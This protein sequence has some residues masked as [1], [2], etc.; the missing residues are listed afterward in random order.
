MPGRQL[1]R[2]NIRRKIGAGA[3][4]EVYLVHDTH[5]DRDVA[6]KVLPSVSLPDEKA[7]YR[8]LAEA[9]AASR[10]N[11]PNICTVHEAGEIDGEVFIA[12]EYV[13]GRRLNDIISPS[14][15]PQEKIVSYGLQLASALAHAHERGIIHRDLKPSNIIVTPQDCLKLLDFGL[16]QRA[17]VIDPTDSTISKA[18]LE[19]VEPGGTLPYSAPEVLRGSGADA[20]SDIWSLGIVFYEMAAGSRP[21]GGRT[22][23]EL[24]SAIFNKP[25]PALPPSMPMGLDLIVQ[26]CLEKEPLH[27]YQ[28]ASE[29][30]AALET[31]SP[32]A[33][34]EGNRTVAHYQGRLSTRW[35][36]LAGALMIAV[37]S[38]WLGIGR[39]PSGDALSKSVAVLP[40]S[41][42]SADA[43]QEYFADGMTDQ[44]ITELGS[45][46][47]LKVISRTS[48]MRYKNTR[49]S[50]PEIAQQLNVGAV[51]Q[52]SVL[53]SGNHIRITV[54]LTD[55]KTDQNLWAQSYERD[56]EDIVRLQAE[57]ASAIALQ[58]RA[59]L[60]PQEQAHLA[61]NVR[62]DPDAYQT[63]LRGRFF[64]EKRTGVG[65]QKALEL[66]QEAISRD[67]T[68]AQPYC[69]LADTYTLERD[70]GLLSF[71][72]ANSLA[73]AAAL[74][75]VEL[76]DTLSEAHTSLASILQD[77]D[78]DW[79]ASEREYRRAIDLNP[80]YATAH[81]W[82]GTLLS[83]LGR[84]GEAIS[85]ETQARELAP[86]SARVAID[87]GYAFF[88][89]RQYD[90]TV[91]EGIEA[92][93]L[94]PNLAGGH[95]LLG[96]AYLSKKLHAQAIKEFREAA[97][98]TRESRT[99][100]AL[101][102]YA[103]ATDGHRE[104][105]SRA[106][107]E[108]SSLPTSSAPFYHIAMIYLALDRKQ[109]AMVALE[110]AFGAKSDKWLPLI[111]VEEAFD[112]LRAEPRFQAMIKR[113]QLTP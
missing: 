82:Y 13:E 15:L 20:R 61:R 64:W 66:F 110:Q 2:Y 78:R 48:M 99:D 3:M 97:A 4:G 56:M 7:R 30:R 35:I 44:L 23:F 105:A 67:P 65:F 94:D 89:A 90:N 85:Q 5:L 54:Q 41:N 87:Q 112:P 32:I 60:T 86:F 63:Y 17:S 98:L 55:G 42:L 104:L 81:Q 96:R 59:K 28:R 38:L 8:L 37:L 51:V 83:V 71:E 19:A 92:L 47:A 14:G 75:A 57:V 106:V 1:G 62:V 76:D 70:Y 18:K 107:A 113:L 34:G 45:I 25:R 21:F 49:K 46:S 109:D 103:Y 39:L 53:R 91:Q 24:T 36:L 52:G 40:L 77:Y 27:R 69:G 43:E 10:L 33:A 74:R 80:S 84:H 26:R 79:I 9:R 93:A 29:L 88:H 100:T 11:H 31:I 16:A 22:V 95:E 68:F 111:G 72:E 6:L 101:L 58:I 102:A 50:L 108:L 73:R 12:M